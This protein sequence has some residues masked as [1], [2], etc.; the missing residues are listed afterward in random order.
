MVGYK[1]I[2]MSNEIQWCTHMQQAGS[3][4]LGTKSCVHHFLDVLLNLS[5]KWLI[6]SFF[7]AVRGLHL[8]ANSCTVLGT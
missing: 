4:L 8:I 1:T 2:S 6:E 5:L 3:E 7:K